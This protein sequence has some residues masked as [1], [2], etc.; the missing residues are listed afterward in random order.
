[1]IHFAILQRK[2]ETRWGDPYAEDNMKDHSSTL[3]EELHF[4]FHPFFFS[5]NFI[6]L[7]SQRN[8]SCEADAFLVFFSHLKTGSQNI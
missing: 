3:P 6:I 4:P 2:K 8:P 5:Q 1:M 7:P